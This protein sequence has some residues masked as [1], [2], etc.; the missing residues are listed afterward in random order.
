MLQGFKDLKATYQAAMAKML[1][2]I[3]WADPDRRAEQIVEL[4][5]QIAAASS[6]HEELRDPAKTY[7]RVTLAKLGRDAPDSLQ[8]SG[9]AVTR[10]SNIEDD[11]F[12]GSF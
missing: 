4:E 6:T 1:R 3:G 11:Q 9:P 7:H 5:T 8:K 12:I 10:S 2:H